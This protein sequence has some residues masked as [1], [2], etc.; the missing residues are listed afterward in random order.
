MTDN[1]S[2]TE[3]FKDYSALQDELESLAMRLFE[4]CPRNY[5]IIG[6]E[7]S[8]RIADPKDAVIN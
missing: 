4:E 2:A 5:E 7:N 8:R 1:K 6:E 3:F